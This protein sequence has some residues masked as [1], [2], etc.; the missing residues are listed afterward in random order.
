[1]K[2][3]SSSDAGA[4][5]ILDSVWAT[6][7]ICG[8]TVHA[9]PELIRQPRD[10]CAGC[11]AALDRER[12]ESELRMEAAVDLVFTTV[13]HLRFAGDTEEAV[14]LI[15]GFSTTDPDLYDAIQR[16]TPTTAARLIGSRAA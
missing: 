10:L 7:A 1:M 14:R 2:H 13:E 5:H 11:Q 8:T 4:P 6:V 15:S 9:T 3:W 16:H 12:G